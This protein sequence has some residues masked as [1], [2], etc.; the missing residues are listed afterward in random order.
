MHDNSVVHG[1]LERLAPPGNGPASE[2]IWRFS[3]R[4]A[5]VYQE[6]MRQFDGDAETAKWRQLYSVNNMPPPSDT[7]SMAD[8][9]AMLAFYSPTNFCKF[10]KL[11]AQQLLDWESRQSRL[12]PYPF[13]ASGITIVDIGAGLGI[14][15]LA[16]IDVLATWAD[17]LAELGYRQ[18]GISVRVVSVE[19]DSKK[20]GPRRKML[21]HLSRLLDSHSVVV[22]NI[23]DVAAPYPEPDCVRQIMEAASRGALAICCMSNFVSSPCANGDQALE[24]F[25]LEPGGRLA[26]APAQQHE[27]LEWSQ[28]TELEDNA[29]AYANATARLLADLPNRNRLLLASELRQ[30]GAAARA[31]ASLLYPGLELSLQWNRVRFYSPHGSY[32]HSLRSGDQPGEPDWATGFWSLAHWGAG[33]TGVASGTPDGLL[34]ARI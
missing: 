3:Q 22:D 9:A 20:Q 21:A 27:L 15:S 25:R 1:L 2:R 17:I 14:A 12:N 18:L 30:R 28:G 4:M 34:S 26:E 24:S 13:G 11:L 6:Q 10:Q 7:R 33:S 23:V 29:V 8:I 19:P 5:S 31:F 16:A 32:W